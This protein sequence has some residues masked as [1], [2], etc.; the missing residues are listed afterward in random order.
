MKLFISLTLSIYFI[1]T[2]SVLAI[3][4]ISLIGL[5]K[6]QVVIEVDGEEYILDKGEETP[7]GVKLLRSDEN[8]MCIK[9]NNANKFKSVKQA[10]NIK[11]ISVNQIVKIK[12]DEQG[13]Y[14]VYGKI[15]GTDVIFMIDTG[16]S[17]IA[18]NSIQADRL[19]LDYKKDPVI[20]RVTT[21]SGREKAFAMRLEE[22]KVNGI[23]VKNVPALII[24]GALPH[25][26]LLGMSFLS[27]VEIKHKGN[28]L[29]LRQK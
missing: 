15:N 25:D 17:H 7:E 13:L 19:G 21:G 20:T 29:L 11:P 9:L 14:R 18:M 5:S 24:E 27:N 10:S 6:D 23:T 16:A 4:R 22:V 1:A 26:I 2:S 12:A 3:D 28:T 8:W